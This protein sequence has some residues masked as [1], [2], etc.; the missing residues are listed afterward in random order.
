M[1]ESDTS[2]PTTRAERVTK[3]E[4][5]APPAPVKMTVEHWAT[6]RGLLPQTLPPLDPTRKAAA[7]LT[8]GS[9]TVMGLPTRHNPEYWKF[10]A[11]KAGNAWPDG[12]EITE[13]DFDDQIAKHTGLPHG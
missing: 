4:P 13:A 6:A 8:V 12:F 11:A 9:A 2:A 5:S 7:T 10:A 3:V 1:G